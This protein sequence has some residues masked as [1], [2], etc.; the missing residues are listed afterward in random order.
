MNGN[1]QRPYGLQVRTSIF[2]P[3]Q[4]FFPHRCKQF[5]SIPIRFGEVAEWSKAVDSKSIVRSRV[6]GVRIPPSPPF[7]CLFL[8]LIS[9]LIFAISPILGD[10]F[11]V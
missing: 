3:L 10:S 1:L 2:W 6:P 7:I 5:L 4:Y 11:G 8:Y 9:N